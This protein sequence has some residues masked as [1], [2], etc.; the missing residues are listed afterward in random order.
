[1]VEIS[2]PGKV[3]RFPWEAK[4]HRSWSSNH[5]CR[6]LLDKIKCLTPLSLTE[7]R[8]PNKPSALSF[9]SGRFVIR[10]VA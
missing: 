5:G 7:L 9:A 1:M 6:K 10:L 8:P 3:V 4:R 2:C